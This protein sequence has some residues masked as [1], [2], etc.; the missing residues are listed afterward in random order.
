LALPVTS[1]QAHRGWL[2]DLDGTLYDPR[3]IKWLMAAE[4]LMFGLPAL[5]G[6]RAFRR[7]HERMRENPPT[8]EEV[9]Q[10]GGPYGLQLMRASQASGIDQAELLRDVQRWMVERP[11]KWLR[12]HRR[13]SLIAEIEGF[14]AAGGKTALVSDYP[15]S[16]KLA[17]MGIA[18]LFDVVVSNGEEGGPAALKPA[19]AGFLS[20]AERLSLTASECLVIGDRD[21]A[22]GAAARAAGM[23]FR[24]V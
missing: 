21:D 20:A 8:A 24:L 19:P 17:A 1:K 3:P 5:A 11:G 18:H 16:K 9:K 6:I 14:R 7:E 2:V 15:A 12:R 13:K 10:G 22:D 23:D 4:L